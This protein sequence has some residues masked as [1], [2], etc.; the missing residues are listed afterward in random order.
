MLDIAHHFVSFSFYFINFYFCWVF[1]K[2]SPVWKV[3]QLGV[4]P[5]TRLVKQATRAVVAFCGTLY[6]NSLH[7]FQF[8]LLV[9]FTRFCCMWPVAADMFPQVAKWNWDVCEHKICL[10]LDHTFDKWSSAF[11]IYGP[12]SWAA[13]PIIDFP[14]VLHI[15]QY[16]GTTFPCGLWSGSG[17]VFHSTIFPCQCTVSTWYAA[18]WWSLWIFISERNPWLELRPGTPQSIVYV[19]HVFFVFVFMYCSF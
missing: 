11:Y 16:G 6:R 2:D 9:S 5:E 19:L 1:S 3:T 10:L 4:T 17:W 15:L 13:I 7:Q 8:T 14:N 18:C 12:E